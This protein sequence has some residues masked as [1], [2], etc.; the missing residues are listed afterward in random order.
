M[1]V[2]IQ[3]LDLNLDLSWLVSS[4]IGAVGLWQW[5]PWEDMDAPF[6]TA[7]PRHV[8]SHGAFDQH[9]HGCVV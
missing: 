7:N 5:E 8:P 3:D 6:D 4:M 2:G 9:P 1:P